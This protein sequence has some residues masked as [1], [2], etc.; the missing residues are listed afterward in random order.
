[1]E[2]LKVVAFDLATLLMSIEGETRLPALLIHDS[3]REA[4]LGE[5]L[6]HQIFRLA[7]DLEELCEQPPFQYIIST[8]SAPPADLEEHVVLRLSSSKVSD[9]L[10]RREP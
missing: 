4:D 9:R 7:A 5:S 1:M 3:P 8:T 6:F 2:A 10:L